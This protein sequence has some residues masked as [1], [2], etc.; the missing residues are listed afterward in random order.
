MIVTKFAL[1]L[2]AVGNVLSQTTTVFSHFNIS[3]IECVCPNSVA[4]PIKKGMNQNRAQK[5]ENN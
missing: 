5:H 1:D 2:R 3:A 4:K